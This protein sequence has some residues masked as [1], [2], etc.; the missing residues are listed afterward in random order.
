MNNKKIVLMRHG[1]SQW[2]QLNQ[3][4]GWKDIKLSEQGKQEALRAAKLLKENKFFFDIAYTSV[5]KRAIHT[6]WIILKKLDCM[7][8]PI[9]KSWRLNERN[10][11]FLEG[12]NKEETIQK[13]GEKKVQLWRRSFKEMPPKNNISDINLIKNDKKYKK[14]KQENIPASESLEMTFKRVIPFWESNILPQ[15]KK[16]KNIIIVAHGNSLRSLI[17]YLNKIN[18]IDIE[19]LDIS[20]GSPIVYEFSY[21]LKP[22]R[23]YYL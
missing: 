16:N 11:G 8:I 12:L 1:E 5:L 20:T 18:D 15:I 22:L 9:H 4:T 14:L 6:L 13:Y 10:Y 2:N 7:W 21:D 3:F 19:K 17:K 23:Y